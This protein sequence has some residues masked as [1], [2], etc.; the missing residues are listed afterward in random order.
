VKCA[1]ERVI[2]L[3][4]CSRPYLQLSKYSNN[5]LDGARVE[6][7]RKYTVR[8]K[9]KSGGCDH[10]RYFITMNS[11]AQC[12]SSGLSG[13]LLT[14]GQPLTVTWYL[15]NISISII[16]DRSLYAQPCMWSRGSIER[17]QI[18]ILILI[19]PS[20]QSRSIMRELLPSLPNSLP[21]T[22]PR[23]LRAFALH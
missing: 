13:D 19:A 17:Y 5:C 7:L 3:G 8:S 18:S 2:V 10:A 14:L 21:A 4:R 20:H 1:V 15:T 12:L 16:T 23:N 11:E 9:I 6:M 22:P